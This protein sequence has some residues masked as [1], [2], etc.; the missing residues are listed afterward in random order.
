MDNSYEFF[1]MAK[2]ETAVEAEPVALAVAVKEVKLTV[3]IDPEDIEL[4]Q[5]LSF[6]KFKEVNIKFSAEISEAKLISGARPI[7][8]RSNIASTSFLVILTIPEDR[9]DVVKEALQRD[10]LISEINGQKTQ[11]G[12]RLEDADSD[13]LNRARLQHSSFGSMPLLMMSFVGLLIA[14]GN[15]QSNTMLAVATALTAS[16]IGVIGYYSRSP[17]I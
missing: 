8:T 9:Y 4:R 17:S 15:F 1:S 11:S 13:R 7:I 3:Q 16:G 14:A 6:S 5:L 12:Q 2:V 10:P